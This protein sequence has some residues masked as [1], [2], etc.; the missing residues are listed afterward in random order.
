[1]W[2]SHISFKSSEPKAKTNE[3][4]MIYDETETPNS[5]QLDRHKILT[6]YES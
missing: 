1:M 6:I 4:I 5:Q 3:I 2:I